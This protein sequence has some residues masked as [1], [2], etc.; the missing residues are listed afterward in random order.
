MVF[1]W[2]KKSVPL[3]NRPDITASEIRMSGAIWNVFAPIMRPS[4]TIQT[5]LS[6]PQS[7]HDSTS[8]QA[9][10]KLHANRRG[11]P[12]QGSHVCVSGLRSVRLSCGALVPILWAT[13]A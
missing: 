4:N 11:I 6:D 9:N 2:H 5:H 12:H 1:T 7:T 10:V 8:D 3:Q 13:S